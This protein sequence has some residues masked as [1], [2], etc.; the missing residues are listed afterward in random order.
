MVTRF[1]LPVWATVAGAYADAARDADALARLAFGP[2]LALS[3]M[4]ALAHLL[5][6][7]SGPSAALFLVAQLLLGVIF[8][9][10]CQRRLLVGGEPDS[11][12]AALAWQ[13]RHWIYLRATLLV[14]AVT[15]AGSTAAGMALVAAAGGALSAS[16]GALLA[17]PCLVASIYVSSRLSIM[18]P[19]AA[20]DAPARP[21]DGWRLTQGNGWRLA[22]VNLIAALPL[23]FANAGAVVL[24][25]QLREGFAL[26]ESATAAFLGALAINAV[27]F[28]GLGVSALAL[29]LA[30][31]G[32]IAAR[33]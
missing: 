28:A 3:L 32:L 13:R 4:V 2:V 25:E 18:L 24:L 15:I 9:S 23:A 7:P 11:V 12:M 17:P 10:A 22:L 33:G 29:A 27:S 1:R 30:Y 19:A 31:R 20:V 6:W 26:T 14:L 16:A 21:A 5:P 8:A